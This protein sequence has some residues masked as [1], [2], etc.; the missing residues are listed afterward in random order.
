MKNCKPG[1]QATK[2]ASIAMVASGDSAIVKE[3]DSQTLDAIS[4]ARRNSLG[5]WKY[6]LVMAECKGVGGESLASRRGY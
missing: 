6:P 4:A 2:R 5:L 1:T 3:P